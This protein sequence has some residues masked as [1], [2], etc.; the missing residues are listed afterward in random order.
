MSEA[1]LKSCPFCGNEAEII[2][3]PMNFEINER[4]Y[5]VRCRSCFCKVGN[6]TSESSAIHA[7]NRRTAD[8]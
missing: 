6:Y 3:Q 8:E 1:K 5:S 2:S 4:T 7:W